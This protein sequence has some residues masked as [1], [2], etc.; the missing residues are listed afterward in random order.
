MSIKARSIAFVALLLFAIA[1]YAIS[2]NNPFEKRFSFFLWSV[3][4]AL[5]YISKSLPKVSR[6]LLFGS[7]YIYVGKSNLLL[8]VGTIICTIAIIPV[9]FWGFSPRHSTSATI[10]LATFVGTI[11]FGMTIILLDTLFSY[12]RRH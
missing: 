10:S 2:S 5:F 11:T 7:K 6:E 3:G 4:G 8:R 9:I 12:Q 1:M